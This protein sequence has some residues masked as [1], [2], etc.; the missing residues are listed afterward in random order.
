VIALGDQLCRGDQKV[1]EI[2]IINP[3]AITDERMQ[4]RSRQVQKQ[5]GGVSE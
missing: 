2:V 4:E 5:I 3:D 1:R